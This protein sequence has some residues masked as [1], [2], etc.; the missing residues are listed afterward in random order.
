LVTLLE[1]EGG[2]SGRGPGEDSA[3]RK[4]TARLARKSRG[5]KP[6]ARPIDEPD[7]RMVRAP[8]AIAPA[9][10]TADSAEDTA[11]AAQSNTIASMTSFPASISTERGANGTEG[12]GV[13]H[14]GRQSRRSRFRRHRHGLRSWAREWR[15]EI[16]VGQGELCVLPQAGLS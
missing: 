12:S 10:V 5:E 13:T 15:R 1:V 3:P 16:G 9:M 11:V 8:Q 4:E 2:G 6:T 7:T 14:G